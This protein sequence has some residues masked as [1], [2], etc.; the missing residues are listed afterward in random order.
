[1]LKSTQ[2]RLSGTASLPFQV[3]AALGY[4]EINTYFC[5][6]LYIVLNKTEIN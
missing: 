1:M 4:L 5:A 3:V 6:R 2:V